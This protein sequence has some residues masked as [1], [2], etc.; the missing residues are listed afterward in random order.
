[1][2]VNER[3]LATTSLVNPG[4]HTYSPHQ[5]AWLATSARLQCTGIKLLL[6]CR[7]VEPPT[8]EDDPAVPRI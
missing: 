8:N 7:R 5:V 4:G 6:Q 3:R 2:R 1:M